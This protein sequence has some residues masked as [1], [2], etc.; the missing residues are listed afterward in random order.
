MAQ[1]S[2]VVFAW[3]IEEPSADIFAIP[4]P[5]APARPSEAARMRWSRRRKSGCVGHA[6]HDPCPDRVGTVIT[7]RYRA[8][9]DR[10]R[11]WSAWLIDAGLDTPSLLVGF[12]GEDLLSW[13][14][15]TGEGPTDLRAGFRGRRAAAAW[16]FTDGA[17]RKRNKSAC[18]RRKGGSMSAPSECASC[19]PG[20]AR[21][22]SVRGGAASRGYAPTT[23]RRTGIAS[24]LKGGRRNR[25]YVAR[26]IS[27]RYGS[28]G[29]RYDS[30]W[31]IS[32]CR[33][34]EPADR[35][36]PAGD[37]RSQSLRTVLGRA[38]HDYDVSRQARPGSYFSRNGY[39]NTTAYT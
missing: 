31:S 27:P 2:N 24:P 7:V 11:L 36:R 22:S 26:P 19:T 39:S 17:R 32:R 10:V 33:R 29:R 18:Y 35:S 1:S 34:H 12:V 14:V 13:V 4:A 38:N 23:R 15:R 37:D 28:V 3:A 25:S 16:I 5:P 6:G 8:P 21:P 9:P 30:T 20:T